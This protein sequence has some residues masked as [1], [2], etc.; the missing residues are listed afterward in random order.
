[1]VASFAE[2]PIS[3]SAPNVKTPNPDPS[4]EG[5]DRDNGESNPDDENVGVVDPFL[6]SLLPEQPYG[7]DVTEDDATLDGDGNVALVEP[8]D[9][10]MLDNEGSPLDVPIDLID[11]E[12]PLASEKDDTTGPDV[13]EPLDFPEVE[14]EVF[15]DG[16]EEG[17]LEAPITLDE[18]TQ[19]PLLQSDSDGDDY[20]NVPIDLFVDD[21]ELPWAK[22]RWTEQALGQT[23]SARRNLALIGNTLCVAGDATHLHDSRSFELLE[24]LPLSQKTA[25]ILALDVEAKSIV[26]L[27]ATG[28]LLSYSRTKTQTQQNAPLPLTR[29]MVSELWQ[30]APGVP[31]VLIRLENGQ[32]LDLGPDGITPHPLPT[33]LSL[34]RLVALSDIGEPRVSLWRNSRNLELWLDAAGEKRKLRLS[35]AMER[36]ASDTRPI[37]IGFNEAVLFGARDHGLWLCPTQNQEF[38]PVPGCRSMTAITV[39]RLGSRPTA[40]VGLFSELEDR[41]EIAVVDLT[42]G[43]ASRIAELCIHSD[44]SGPEDDPPELARIDALVWDQSNGK[45]WVAGCFGLTCFSQ[46]V[47]VTSS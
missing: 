22:E 7:E 14:G 42:T 11:D 17:P 19:S 28:Q 16:A 29:A 27:T 2:R 38:H 43:R 15:T 25:R 30:L 34:L 9:L 4:S 35:P 32:L 47:G 3:C 13:T 33:N 6:D 1:M 40:F 41:A 46:P 26:L 20:G 5:N 37:L 23:F 10:D 45:L 31:T 24:T 36:I 44:C 12:V 39:G 21:A 8:R 18:A